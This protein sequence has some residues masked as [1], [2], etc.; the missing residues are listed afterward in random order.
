[1]AWTI[2][3]LLS[4][5]TWASVNGIPWQDNIYI[6][7]PRYQETLE[8]CFLQMKESTSCKIYP[9]E[10]LQRI[11]GT[12]VRI[13]ILFNIVKKLG[14]MQVILLRGFTVA[15]RFAIKEV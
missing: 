13:L 1:M 10:R 4:L 3:R 7:P 11:E 5:L 14:Q 9:D 8:T 15:C 2:L 6:Y 12:K